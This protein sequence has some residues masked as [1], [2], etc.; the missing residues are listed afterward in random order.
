MKE[1]L[2]CIDSLECAGAEKSLVTL[3]SSIDYTKYKVDL[4]LFGYGGDL[5]AVLPREVLLLKPLKYTTFT[6]LSL[7]KSLKYSIK[8]KNFKMLL[9]RLR[10]SFEI[11]RKNYTN[12]EKARIF[13]ESISKNIESGE[14]T[15]DIAI[16]YAQGIPTF[17]VAE[18]IRAVKKFAWV[19]TSLELGE[20]D[21]N[22]QEKFY[23]AYE[24]IVAVSDSARDILS[25][26][27][28]K[29]KNK[30][31]VIYD[32]NNPK[33]INEMAVI[34][35]SYS[36]SFKGLKIL[37]IGRLAEGKGYEYALEACRILKDKKINFRWYVLGRGPLREEM[38]MKIKK[39]KLEDS[40]ILLGVAP[41]PYGYIKNSDI[42][43]QT[44]KFEGFGLAIAEARILNIPVVTTKFDAVY[45]QMVDRKNGIVT[46]ISGEAVA[47]GII[48]MI[49]NNSLRKNI[50][51]YLMN[52]KKGNMEEIEKFYKLIEG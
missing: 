11:R 13:W 6:E 51:E 43:V 31:E 34:G 48:E 2:F 28:P 42:Y 24:K 9:S 29:F 32:I 16:S 12:P 10:Y 7:S 4:Q 14:K 39:M 26:T 22:F 36:D 15:Y 25:R 23:E 47:K 49:E 17:Y 38:E 21:K 1:I 52:E 18:K 50:I 46:D 3:L 20:R 8:K 33:M 45:N 35:E 19:N 40:F 44:S 5:E 37:T 30:I 27:F 41:N